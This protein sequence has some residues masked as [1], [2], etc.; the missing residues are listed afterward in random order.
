MVTVARITDSYASNMTPGY[1]AVGATHV[2]NADP[3]R[4]GHATATGQG[5]G[6]RRFT[7]VWRTLFNE[8]CE[9]RQ[10]GD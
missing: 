1:I 9:R 6:F 10:M 4:Y 3:G 2:V 5:A 7:Q 8:P